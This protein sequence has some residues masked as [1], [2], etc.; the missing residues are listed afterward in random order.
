MP[1]RSVSSS[2]SSYDSTD[3]ST[4]HFGFLKS[5][6]YDHFGPSADKPPAAFHLRKRWDVST[7]R[8]CQILSLSNDLRYDIH[9]YYD[10]S[11]WKFLQPG[12]Q[13]MHYRWQRLSFCYPNPNYNGDISSDINYANDAYNPNHYPPRIAYL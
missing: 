10:M 13:V 1:Y 3:P 9:V 6:N 8:L 4:N 12:G 2:A 7:P 5:S 11:T